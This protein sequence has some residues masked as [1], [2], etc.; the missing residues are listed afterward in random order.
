MHD[1][2]KREITITP[3]PPNLLTFNQQAT[4]TFKFIEKECMVLLVHVQNNTFRMTLI[5]VE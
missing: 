2:G 3:R 5:N 1:D 4:P